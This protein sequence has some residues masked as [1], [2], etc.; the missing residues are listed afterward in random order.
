MAAVVVL[1]LI[2]FNDVPAPELVQRSTKTS[3]LGC[4]AAPEW[5]RVV[6]RICKSGNTAGKTSVRDRSGC[7]GNF[8]GSIAFSV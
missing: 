8:E 2:A 1:R 7:F 4:L 3:E 5:L 6:V